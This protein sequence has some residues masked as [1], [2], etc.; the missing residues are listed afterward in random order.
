MPQITP[1]RFSALILFAL[2]LADTPATA[3]EVDETRRIAAEWGAELPPPAWDGTRAD[4]LHG[5]YVIEVEWSHGRKWYEA[6]GQALHY[7]IVYDRKPAIILL[8][9]PDKF[10]P[11]DAFRCQAVCAKHGI[12]LWIVEAKL[13]ERQPEGNQ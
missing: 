12:R 10:A 4:L 6:V 3:S 5:E 9:H 13:Y 11:Q 7:A 1:M 2:L 8:R